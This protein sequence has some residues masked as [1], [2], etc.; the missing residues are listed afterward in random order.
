LEVSVR[1]GVLSDANALAGIVLHRASI[2]SAARFAFPSGG[3]EISDTLIQTQ[4]GPE[5]PLRPAIFDNGTELRPDAHR[6]E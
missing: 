5:H 6:Y 1:I 4:S 3:F 2:I